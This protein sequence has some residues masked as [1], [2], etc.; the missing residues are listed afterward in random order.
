MYTC[1]PSD[2]KSYDAIF[3]KILGGM[4]L[5]LQNGSTHTVG[6]SYSGLHEEGEVEH[7]SELVEN[8]AKHVDM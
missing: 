6:A 1:D 2:T 4:P 8:W 5:N 3:A 7:V